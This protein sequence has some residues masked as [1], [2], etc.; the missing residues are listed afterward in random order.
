MRISR[1]ALSLV[2]LALGAACGGDSSAAEAGRQQPVTASSVSFV[3]HPEHIQPGLTRQQP[4]A[5]LR[6]PYGATKARVDEGS[7][8]F[9]AYNCLDCHGA[10]GSGAMGPSLADGRWHFGGTDGEVFQS[11][12]EGRPDGMPSWGARISDE[13]IWALVAY[14]QSLSL[15]KNVTTQ[16]FSGKTIE[17]M[18][19]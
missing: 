17:K 12:Y 3:D 13:Q 11:I 2:G 10:D 1:S 16:N 5:T 7:K 6:N 15:G 9:V 18:G 19:H 4:L 8:L 14:V